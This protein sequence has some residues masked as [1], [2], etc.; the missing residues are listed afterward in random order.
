MQK[1]NLKLLGTML[2][3]LVCDLAFCSLIV[4]WTAMLNMFFKELLSQRLGIYAWL[5]ATEREWI[6][7]AL[8]VSCVTSVALVVFVGLFSYWH[9]KTFVTTFKRSQARRL[10]AR[11]AVMPTVAMCLGTTRFLY[12]FFGL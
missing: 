5:S 2:F 10:T 6:Y 3:L 1:L 9:Y 12:V 8:V 4:L 7:F 11:L